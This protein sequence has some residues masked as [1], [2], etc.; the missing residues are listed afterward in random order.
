MGVSPWLLSWMKQGLSSL[1]KSDW[2]DCKPLRALLS[3]PPMSL[4]WNTTIA[5]MHHCIW[6]SIFTFA[7]THSAEHLTSPYL[8][9][10][11]LSNAVIIFACQSGGW[12]QSRRESKRETSRSLFLLFLLILCTWSLQV[13]VVPTTVPASSRKKVSSITKWIFQIAKFLQ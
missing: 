10:F 11:C 13:L 1:Y 2:L 5:D 7:Q 3:I 8:Y 12:R 4:Y 6:P 9:T